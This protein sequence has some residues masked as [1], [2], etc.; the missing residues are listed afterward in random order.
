MIGFTVYKGYTIRTYKEGVIITV[1][2]KIIKEF[3]N[4]SFK[5]GKEKA[6]KWIDKKINFN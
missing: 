6:K 3:K 2:A 4:V 5:E 1:L